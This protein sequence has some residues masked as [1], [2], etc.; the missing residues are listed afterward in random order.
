MLLFV[1]LGPQLLPENQ[2]ICVRGAKISLLKAYIHKY[3]SV[4]HRHG[5]ARSINAAETVRGS[6]TCDE[7]G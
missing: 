3:N 4:G 6:F 2:Y 7:T 1:P 5:Y